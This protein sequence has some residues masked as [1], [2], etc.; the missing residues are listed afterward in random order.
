MFES[1]CVPFDDSDLDFDFGAE[2]D[3]GIIAIIFWD[4]LILFM[5][6]ITFNWFPSSKIMY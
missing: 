6:Q 5:L 2:T 4:F 1:V 3:N